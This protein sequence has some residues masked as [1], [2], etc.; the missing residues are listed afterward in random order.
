MKT[1]IQTALIGKQAMVKVALNDLTAEQSG[2]I[3]AN[4]GPIS[5]DDRERDARMDRVWPKYPATIV[6]VYIQDGWLTPS[7]TVQKRDG[8]LEDVTGNRVTVL[9]LKGK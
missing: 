4:G 2:V 1:N 6:S 3:L 8:T 9:D 5:G 7:Y